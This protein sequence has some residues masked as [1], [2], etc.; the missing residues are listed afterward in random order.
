MLKRD[1]IIRWLFASVF[2]ALTCQAVAQTLDDI[3]VAVRGDDAVAHVSFI[4]A[5]RLVQQSTVAPTRLI[6]FQIELLAPDEAS[7]TQRTP[8]SRRVEAT[9]AAPG[10]SLVLDAPQT[11]NV[12]MRQMTMQISEETPVRAHQ[13]ANARTIDIVFVGRGR[14]L[15]ALPQLDAPKEAAPALP[16]GQA[17]AP[18]ATSDTDKRAQELMASARE[19]LSKGSYAAAIAQ[20]NQLL[21]LPPNPETQ[22]AQELIGLAWERSGDLVRAKMEYDL[23]LKLF[24]VGEGAQRVAQRLASMGTLPE[25]PTAPREGAAPAPGPGPS[26]KYTGNIAQYYFGGKS[27]TQ[28]LVNLVSG[29]D[30]ATLSKTTESALVTNIDLGARYATD[31]SDIRAVLRGTGSANL[32]TKSQNPSILNAA[33]VDYRQKDNGLAVRL[34]RQSPING[35]LLGLFDGVSLSYPVRPGIRVNLMG[36]VPANPLV[37]APAEVMLAG[38]VEADAITPNLGGD[39]YLIEQTTEG[40]VNRRAIGTEVHY[41]NER[42]SMYGLLDYDE[43]FR[44][45]NAVSLQGSLQGGGQTT[46]TVLLDSRKAPSLEATNALISTGAVS[47]KTL[48]QMMTLEEVLTTAKAT[49]AQARQILFSASR[50]VSE[51]WQ[52]TGD[53]RYSDIGALPAV[54][55]FAATPA[56]GGQQGFSLQFTGTNL[57]SKRD[58]NNFN[59]T[60]MTTP[61]FHGIQLAYN[62][63]TGFADN[64]VTMEPSLRL[65]MQRDA[66]GSSMTRVTPGL[67]GSY[68]FSKRLS[69]TSEAMIEHS[70]IQGLTNNATSNSVFFYIGLRYELF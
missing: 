29:I 51:K 25:K 39:L 32:S 58:I 50:P 15:P 21:L 67:R 18:V 35:G 13:G 41:A 57:Y 37:T 7:L 49:S 11:P 66:L 34:G 6:Q 62:N 59:L 36:G 5:V 2:A 52:A 10:F 26:V 46:Y 19:A 44:A 55:N 9:G 38:M 24:S 33:Y 45:V 48:L 31:A 47:L 65:Y 30:Q 60:V 12:R 68:N 16:T 40:I 64:K 1:T 54:G 3:V 23:Y 17:N 28:S 4:G 70:T 61:F 20:F 56:T 53:I 8:E 14:S 63:L 69:L 42:G 43:L 22:D 27:R